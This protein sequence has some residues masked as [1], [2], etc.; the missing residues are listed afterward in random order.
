MHVGKQ[1]VNGVGRQRETSWF[2]L[3]CADR[4][5]EYAAKVVRAVR[6]LVSGERLRCSARSGWMDHVVVVDYLSLME[7]SSQPYYY[8]VTLTV[9]PPIID[10]IN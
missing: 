8:I 2:A 9:S 1:R 7:G 10:G 6:S 3:V 5:N 4:Q